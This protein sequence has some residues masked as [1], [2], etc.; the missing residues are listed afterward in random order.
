MERQFFR[1]VVRPNRVKGSGILEIVMLMVRFSQEGD[2]VWAE[3]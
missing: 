1:T 3:K 2:C